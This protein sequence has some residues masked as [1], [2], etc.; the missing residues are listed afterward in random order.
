MA[1]AHMFEPVEYLDINSVV[2]LFVVLCY[3]LL[4]SWVTPVHGFDIGVAVRPRNGVSQSTTEHSAYDFGSEAKC[5]NFRK[6]FSSRIAH[7]AGG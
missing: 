4:P 1:S 3:T 2:L 5:S 6:F 7:T